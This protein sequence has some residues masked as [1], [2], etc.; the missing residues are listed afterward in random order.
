VAAQ[1][2]IGVGDLITKVGDQSV[3]SAQNAADELAKHDLKKGVLLTITS[4]EGDRL[5]FV[6]SK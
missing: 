1:H 6:K 3:T 5:V 4:K 2:G